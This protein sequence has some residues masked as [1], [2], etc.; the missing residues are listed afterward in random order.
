MIERPPDHAQTAPPP[1]PSQEERFD[2]VFR[3]RLLL[4]LA[5]LPPLLFF[6]FLVFWF[7]EG[8][9][10]VPIG[11]GF[12]LYMLA[13]FFYFQNPSVKARHHQEEKDKNNSAE[14]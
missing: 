12:Y 6:C 8:F 11:L 1:R 7:R 3:T 10:L 9:I 14:L 5:L 2:A 4:S 13:E